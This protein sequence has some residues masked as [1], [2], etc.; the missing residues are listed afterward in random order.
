MKLSNPSTQ[1]DEPL[2]SVQPYDAPEIQVTPAHLRESSNFDSEAW[3]ATPELRESSN[4]M[5]LEISVSW[6]GALLDIAHYRSPR[7][8]TFGPDPR[9]DFCYALASS[10]EHPSKI[11]LFPLIEPSK[12]GGYLLCF[13]PDMDGVIEENGEQHK[14]LDLVKAG[15]AHSFDRTGLCYYPLQPGALVQLVCTESIQ[16]RI[17]FVTAPPI[18]KTWFRYMD[19]HAPVLSFSIFIHLLMTFLTILSLASPPKTTATQKVALPNQQAATN[20]SVKPLSAT[21]QVPPSLKQMRSYLLPEGKVQ[22]QLVRLCPLPTVSNTKK[23]TKPKP[24]S[25]S[26][27]HRQNRN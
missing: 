1:R 27:I 25:S 5:L 9:A 7:R 14:L 4:G 15:R 16:I 12:G 13:D 2:V 8:L 11:S 23:R 6:E 26:C 20:P 24:N 17:R 22:H 10:L 19:T 18:S 21:K 3:F